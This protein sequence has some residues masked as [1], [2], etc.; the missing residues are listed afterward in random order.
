MDLVDPAHHH[1]LVGTRRDWMVIQGRPRDVQQ[2]ELRGC[3]I[4]VRSSCVGAFLSLPP[5][6]HR[7]YL[8]WPIVNSGNIGGNSS[9]LLSGQRRN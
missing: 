1:Y 4:K 6:V 3:R 5:R 2:P 8:D 7:G 9:T